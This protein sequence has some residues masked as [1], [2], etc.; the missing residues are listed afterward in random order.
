MVSTKPIRVIYEALWKDEDDTITLNIGT[1]G[2]SVT[3]GQILFTLNNM[4]YDFFKNTD[5]H[6]FEGLVWVNG[7]T[8]KLMIGS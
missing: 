6:F 8:C 1:P 4:T 3:M 2:I 7:T 5:Y